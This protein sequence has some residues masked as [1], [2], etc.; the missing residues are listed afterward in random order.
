MSVPTQFQTAPPTEPQTEAPGARLGWWSMIRPLVL[1]LHFYAGVLVAP[2][3]LVASVTGL[4]YTIAPQ[5]E[6]IA[7]HDLTH[8]TPSG[9]QATL[10][11]QVAAARAS[12]PG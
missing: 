4:L 10:A 12:H 11:E 7:Y 2:F 1:R 3:I 6:Q 8:V 9:D 5:V